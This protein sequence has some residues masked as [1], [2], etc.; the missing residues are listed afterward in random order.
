MARIV[1]GSYVVRFPL[2]GYQSWALQW[3]VGFKRLG[4]EVYFV[5]KS[6]WANSCYD[7][8]KDA[9]TDDCSY[10]LAA[11]EALL[12]RF[13]LQER[14]CYVDATGCYRGLSKLQVEAAFASADVFVDM[15]THGSWLPEARGTGVRL[16]VDGDPGYTQMRALAEEEDL[17]EYDYYYTVGQNVGTAG[18]TV[19]TMGLAWRRIFDPVVSELFPGKSPSV[20]FVATAVTVS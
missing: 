13:D 16:L 11:L 20:I 2:G 17:G 8:T 4:H 7:P 1:V 14:W 9:M 5:E 3:L 19:P 15:G 10:G 18:C 12:R 6:G